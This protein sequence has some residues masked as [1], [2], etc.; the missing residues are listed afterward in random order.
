MK[1]DELLASVSKQPVFETGLLLAGE[2][3]PTDVHRQISR[4]VQAGRVIQLRRGLY[5][6]ADPYL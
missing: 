1:F 6:L 3:D 4:W 5:T 2:V